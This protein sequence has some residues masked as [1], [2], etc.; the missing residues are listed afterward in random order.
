MTNAMLGPALLCVGS[1]EATALYRLL[2]NERIVSLPPAPDRLTS[3]CTILQHL[4]A[5]D[6]LI[7][8][9]FVADGHRERDRLASKLRRRS[10]R[11][12]DWPELEFTC[13]Q[14]AFNPMEPTV[15]KDIRVMSFDREDDFCSPDLL[16]VDADHVQLFEVIHM[17]STTRQILVLGE[18]NDDVHHAILALAGR[19]GPPRWT[20][21]PIEILL[22][23]APA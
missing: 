20:H 10:R 6:M 23:G 3:C 2:D 17:V 7:R 22:A 18:P 11:L 14:S 16:V 15:H 4:V 1:P 8:I 5:I 9:T 13:F 21:T 12:D 19:S